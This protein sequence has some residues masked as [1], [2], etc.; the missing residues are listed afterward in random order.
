MLLHRISLA[1]VCCLGL[2]CSP[3]ASFAEN[4]R[5]VHAS[6]NAG[7]VDVL[8][9][10]S[11]S[12]T[13]PGLTY[14]DTAPDATGGYANLGGPGVFSFQVNEAGTA[15]QLLDTGNLSLGAGEFRTVIATGLNGSVGTVGDPS[16]RPFTVVPLLDDRTSV[17]GQARVRFFHAST[18]APDVDIVLENGMDTPLWEDVAYG[19]VGTTTMAF[20]MSEYLQVPAGM[21]DLD[22]RLS[23]DGT[24]ALDL[25][26][27][28]LQGGFVYTV[29]AVGEAGNSENPLSALVLVDAVPSP[30]LAGFVIPAGMLIARR[31]R[32]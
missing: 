1:S 21:Y 8:L 30:G 4:V 14:L 18:N 7:P 12:P 17:P 28:E 32:R 29:I 10:G 11:M 26:P 6:G 27:L 16:M 3:S 24:S 13:I 9:N 19:T 15:N 20:G 31:A 2:V 23:G 5:V 25:D 22:V